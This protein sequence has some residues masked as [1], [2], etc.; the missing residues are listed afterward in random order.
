MANVVNLNNVSNCL[1][2]LSGWLAERP[3]IPIPLIASHDL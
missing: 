2:H 3:P 1:N